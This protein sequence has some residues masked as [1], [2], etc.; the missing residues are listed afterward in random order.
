MAI[1]KVLHF[2]AGLLIS[3]IVGFTVNP[4]WAIFLGVIAGLYKELWDVFY[5]GMY[6]DGLPLLLAK[7][8]FDFFDLFVTILG[9]VVGTGIVVALI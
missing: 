7:D 6:R 8:R 5:K 2:T 1:D 4:I 9:A 3:L